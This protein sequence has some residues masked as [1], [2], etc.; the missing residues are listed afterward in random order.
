[1]I[2]KRKLEMGNLSLERV[3]SEHDDDDDVVL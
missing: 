3:S 1:V 2:L